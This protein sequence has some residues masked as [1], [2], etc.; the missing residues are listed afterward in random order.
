M[1][2]LCHHLRAGQRVPLFVVAVLLAGAAAAFK[3]RTSAMRGRAAAGADEFLSRRILQHWLSGW[4]GGQPEQHPRLQY[5]RADCRAELISVAGK[6]SGQGMG[7]SAC[8]VRPDALYGLQRFD[9][10]KVHFGKMRQGDDL[11]SQ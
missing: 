11:R 10:G 1:C 2:V 9:V 6:I 4:R 5:V 7:K 3:L 8:N